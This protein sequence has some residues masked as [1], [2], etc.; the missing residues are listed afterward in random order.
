MTNQ[1]AIPID[2]ISIG[3]AIDAN[4]NTGTTVCLFDRPATAGVHIM[5]AAP[6]TRDTELLGPE[7]AVNEIDAIVLS[8]GSAF[9]LDAAGGTQAWLKQEG[10]GVPLDPVRIPIVP[11]AILF[12]MRNSGDKEWGQYS[13]YRE[14]GYAATVAADTTCALGAVGA[15]YGASTA[16]TPGGFGIASSTL[17]NGGTIMAMAA[18]NAAGSPLIGDTQHFWAAPFEEQAEFG[19]LG[20][21]H[22]W[23]DDAKVGR[24][25]S[26]QR[27]AGANTTLAIVVTD[28]ALDA[29][30]A[31]RIAIASHDGFARALYPVHTPA[32]GDL[33]FAAS[34]NQIEVGSEAMLD[35]GVLAANV[36]ARAIAR[37][38]YEAMQSSSANANQT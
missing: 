21:P 14:L 37:G 12:D 20:M 3:H 17:T 8:G 6:G 10:R 29:G 16:N 2:G 5:G 31:K 13:P 9:G 34:T 19:G 33:I 35:L 18:V 24:M 22:P 38:V 23:P 11:C 4:V 30:A 32:D 7:Y 26:G 15:A 36:T 1:Y 28:I 27:V 25:K